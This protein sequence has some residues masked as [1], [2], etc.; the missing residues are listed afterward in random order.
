MVKYLYV[1]MYRTTVIFLIQPSKVQFE[2]MYHDHVEFIT[3]SEYRCMYKD[4][5]KNDKCGGFTVPLKKGDVVLC[6]KDIEQR[7]DIAHEILHTTNVILKRR[8]I[9]LDPNNDEP[10][11]YLV[12]YLTDKFYEYIEEATNG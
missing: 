12:S 10:Q 5:F 8:G 9:R 2:L 7:G 11:A 1:E 6:V 4:L 3:D